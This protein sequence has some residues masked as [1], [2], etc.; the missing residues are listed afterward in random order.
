M[1]F[2]TQV[3]SFAQ[4]KCWQES[5]ATCAVSAFRRIF[6]MFFF[7]CRVVLLKDINAHPILRKNIEDLDYLWVFPNF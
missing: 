4:Q 1:Y 2:N 3:Q 7:S 5:L 6:F